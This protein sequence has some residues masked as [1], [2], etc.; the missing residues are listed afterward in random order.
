MIGY[1][2][3]N[4]TVEI[5]SRPP[6]ETLLNGAESLVRTLLKSGIDTCFA[7]PGT[8]ELHFVSALDRIPGMRCVLGLFEGVVTGVRRWLRPHGG[9]TGG[10]AVA[11]RPWLG[12]WAC[13]SAQCSPGLHADGEYR[14]RPG[15]SPSPSGRAAHRGYRGL[16][17]TRFRLGPNLR[18]C[19]R[20]GLR[21]CRSGASRPHRAG[22]DRN[23]HR[24]G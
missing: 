7:N 10:H 3:A 17:A 18:Q 9:E 19:R 23:P 6:R 16:G 1:G 11:L 22:P 8:S 4:P 24:A 14:G 2:C 12:E 5:Q 13:Q 21:R 15:D 20:R